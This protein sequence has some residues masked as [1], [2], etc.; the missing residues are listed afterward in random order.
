MLLIAHSYVYSANAIEKRPTEYD[1]Y[2][3]VYVCTNLTRLYTEELLVTDNI[4]WL[5]REQNQLGNAKLVTQLNF[6]EMSNY[7]PL[8]IS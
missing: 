3:I 5:S 1:L 7:K 8:S 6:S 4:L 2:Y